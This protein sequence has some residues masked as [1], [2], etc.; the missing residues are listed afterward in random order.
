MA[1]RVGAARANLVNAPRRLVETDCAFDQPL[2]LQRALLDERHHAWI[3]DSGAADQGAVGG[4]EP[5]PKTGCGGEVDLLRNGYQ[6]VIGGV[7]GDVLSER[8]PVGEAWL[9]LIGTDLGLPGP[10][11]FTPTAAADEWDSH[12]VADLPVTD[13]GAHRYILST[14]KP[15]A[16]AGRA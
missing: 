2:G 9:L 11:P 12:P 5:A 16:R 4:G 6:V 7:Q 8:P 1:P 10:A 14:R 13:L 15:P 3:V